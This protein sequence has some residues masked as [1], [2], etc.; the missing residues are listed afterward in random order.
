MK[1]VVPTQLDGGKRDLPKRC[2]RLANHPL[3]KVASSKHAE[4]VVLHRFDVVPETSPVNS[5]VREA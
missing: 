3:T 5:E 2:E 4:V 1:W